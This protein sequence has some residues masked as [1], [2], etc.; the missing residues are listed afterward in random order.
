M[1]DRGTVLFTGLTRQPELAG[2]PVAFV[3]AAAVL[4][5]ITFIATQTFWDFWGLLVAFP[6]YVLCLA[7]AKHDPHIVSLWK[8]SQ[9]KT[10]K[11]RNWR[12][13]GGNS[14]GA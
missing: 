6:S 10:G 3:G 12:L 2:I 1:A 9:F 8:V 13:W 11:R 7:L 14:Y 5:I 4:P